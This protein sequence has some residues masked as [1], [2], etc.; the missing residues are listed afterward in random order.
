M[1]PFLKKGRK[2]KSFNYRWSKQ[3]AIYQIVE[4]VSHR[5]KS[6]RI[7][8]EKRNHS[9]TFQTSKNL[10]NWLVFSFSSLRVFRRRNFRAVG[11]ETGPARHE[12]EPTQ[13]WDGNAR[14]LSRS[15]S[16]RRTTAEGK[17]H[18]QGAHPVKRDARRRASSRDTRGGREAEARVRHS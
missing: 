13:C 5:R 12:I 10:R 11:L 3:K 14:W 9:P 1:H 15:S 8:G 16:A 6:S 17:V 18:R 7:H 2:E 4:R